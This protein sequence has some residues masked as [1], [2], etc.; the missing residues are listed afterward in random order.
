M[1][2]DV[3]EATEGLK[4]ELCRRWS[5][6]K[7]GE[8][9]KL[10]VIVIAELIL[11]PL[12]HFTHVYIPANYSHNSLQHFNIS[13]FCFIS[14]LFHCFNIIWHSNLSLSRN[15]AKNNFKQFTFFIFDLPICWSIAYIV[16]Y[17]HRCSNYVVKFQKCELMTLPSSIH[18]DLYS[19]KKCSIVILTF[20]K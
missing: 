7:V 9:A 19:I 13:H 11:Q 10:I 14:L 4:N 3:G 1:N 20:S 2:C 18:V 8:W 15:S 17:M 6:G 12:R 5:D 16:L